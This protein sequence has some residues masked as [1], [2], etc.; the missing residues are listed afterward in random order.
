MFF[1]DPRPGDFVEGQLSSQ[2]LVI[3][4]ALEEVQSTAKRQRC[5]VTLTLLEGVRTAK[6][7]R[8]IAERG[9]EFWRSQPR[10]TGDARDVELFTS[11]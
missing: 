4:E 6:L 2:M 5:E 7:G 11:D 8:D 9:V 10:G 3:V 1:L